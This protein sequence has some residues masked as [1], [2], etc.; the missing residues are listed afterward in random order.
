MWFRSRF[1]TEQEYCINN[2]NTIFR[3]GAPPPLSRYSDPRINICQQKKKKKKRKK[4]FDFPTRTFKSRKKKE[5]GIPGAFFLD[6]KKRGAFAPLLCFHSQFARLNSPTVTSELKSA[7]TFRLLRA[8]SFR[9]LADPNSED[10]IWR[11]R[12]SPPDDSWVA[13]SVTAW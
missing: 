13:Y 3:A 12:L 8:R 11:I 4:R 6:K 10:T 9:T 1:K 5:T 2:F 7:S